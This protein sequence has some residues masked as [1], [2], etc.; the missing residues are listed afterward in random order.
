MNI[1][2]SPDVAQVPKGYA[3]VPLHVIRHEGLSAEAVRL[4]AALD[5]RL[6]GRSLQLRRD[7]LAR[8]IAAGR[9]PE[10]AL[11]A[12]KRA[13]AELIEAGLLE[14]RRTGRAS[15]YTLVNVKRWTTRGPSDGS[16]MGHRYSNKRESNTNNNRRTDRPNPRASA[17]ALDPRL[18]PYLNAVAKHCPEVQPNK[19]VCAA[20]ATIATAHTPDELARI[21]DSWALSWTGAPINDRAGWT[22]HRLKEIAQAVTRGQPMDVAPER[23]SP[24]TPPY[25]DAPPQAT[26]SN[27]G[28]LTKVSE[29]D[30]SHALTRADALAAMRATIAA[31]PR[32]H[33]RTYAPTVT[34]QEVTVDAYA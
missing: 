26:P 19:A 12:I 11:A 28:T 1:Q 21:L 17:P 32:P 3:L 31:A 24:P 10:A 7:T 14:V 25:W 16:N 9:S 6:G 27:D 30:L 34:A 13:Q 2:T 8:D 20:L 29:E 23:T 22:V 18:L 4:Y 15:I 33:K 5:G